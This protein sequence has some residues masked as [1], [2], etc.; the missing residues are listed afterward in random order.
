MFVVVFN[1]IT[2]T[3][4]ASYHVAFIQKKKENEYDQEIPQ[5]CIDAGSMS[6]ILFVWGVSTFIPYDGSNLK[7]YLQYR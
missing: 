1:F 6:Y 7:T 5:S 3:I 2:H 4:G